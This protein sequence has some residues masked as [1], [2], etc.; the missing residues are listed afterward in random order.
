[1]VGEALSGVGD[2]AKLHDSKEEI[3][4][5]KGD[6]SISLGELVCADVCLTICRFVASG[7]TSCCLL[8]FFFFLGSS[9]FRPNPIGRF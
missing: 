2:G 3:E 9:I 5:R 1:M 6:K 4:K 7:S 8:L